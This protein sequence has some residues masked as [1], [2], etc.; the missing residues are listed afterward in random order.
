MVDPCVGTIIAAKSCV[1]LSKQFPFVR[2]HIDPI[3]FNCSNFRSFWNVCKISSQQ[4]LRYH[5]K[6]RSARSSR[7]VRGADGRDKC[8]EEENFGNAPAGLS[9]MQQFPAQ[10]ALPVEQISRCDIA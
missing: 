9:P 2:C 1:M 4:R 10:F 5:E 6:R 8:A 7:E 3:C